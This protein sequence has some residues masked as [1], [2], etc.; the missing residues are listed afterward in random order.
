MNTDEEYIRKAVELADNW[1]VFKPGQVT[2]LNGLVLD[3]V[4][5]DI[6]MLDALAAQLVRQVDGD[7][8]SVC[9]RTDHSVVERWEYGK[10]IM[11]SYAEGSDRTMNTI[12]RNAK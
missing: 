12:K 7:L 4:D 5:P 2:T 8:H 6:E 9:V 3:L 11:E 10:P 1:L